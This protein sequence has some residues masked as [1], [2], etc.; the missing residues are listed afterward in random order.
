MSFHSF[1]LPLIGYFPKGDIKKKNIFYP[2]SVS[3][4]T[5]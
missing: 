1:I 2:A 4:Q 3:Q 5:L